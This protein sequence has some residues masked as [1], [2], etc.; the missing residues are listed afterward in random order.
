MFS[1]DYDWQNINYLFT[2]CY[3]IDL[4]IFKGTHSEDNRIYL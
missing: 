3:I 4:V 1:T 2:I